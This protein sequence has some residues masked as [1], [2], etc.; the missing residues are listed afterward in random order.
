MRP[1][2]LFTFGRQGEGAYL[3]RDGNQGQ[4]AYFFSK[5]QQSVQNKALN[6]YLFEKDKKMLFFL[7]PSKN[8]ELS[9]RGKHFIRLK[10]LCSRMDIIVERL[11]GS[12]LLL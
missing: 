9:K 10:E 5:N 3:K 11:R 2:R 7:H 1:R 8:K 6:E 12:S 4:G